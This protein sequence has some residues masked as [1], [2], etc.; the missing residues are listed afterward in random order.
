MALV[1]PAPGAKEQDNVQD[2]ITFRP[3][4]AVP[5]PPGLLLGAIGFL[6]LLGRARWN[7]RRATA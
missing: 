2:Q 4:G 6:G 3:K 5:A 1:A 7:R